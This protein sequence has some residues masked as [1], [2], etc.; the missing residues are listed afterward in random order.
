MN[1]ITAQLIARLL[2]FVLGVAGAWISQHVGI[3]AH[4]ADELSVACV[5]GATT[6]AT[7]HFADAQWFKALFAKTG[8]AGQEIAA[9][10]HS[11]EAQAALENA[12]KGALAAHAQLGALQAAAVP[13][14]APRPVS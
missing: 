4:A 3:S 5:V 11:P 13:A 14:P 2:T 10:L 9:A 12:V 1:E 8:S 7:K 6:W